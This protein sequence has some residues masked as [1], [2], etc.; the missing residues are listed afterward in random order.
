MGF[1]SKVKE[2][3][4]TKAARHCCVCHR[5]RGL[6]I[7]VHHI[8]PKAE[9][10]E[11]T[12][13]NAISLCFDCHA[14]AGHYNANHP[15][16]TKFSPSELR[17]ARNNWFK[18]VQEKSLCSP[19]DSSNLELHSRYYVTSELDVVEEILNSCWDNL[20]VKN[21]LLLKNKIYIFMKKFLKDNSRIIDDVNY[22]RLISQWGDSFKTFNEVQSKHSDVLKSSYGGSSKTV[23]ERSFNNSDLSKIEDPL[24]HSLY[25]EGID[26]SILGEAI[27]YEDFCGES[28]DGKNIVEQLKYRPIKFIFLEIF[29]CSGNQQSLTSYECFSRSTDK[30][31]PFPLKQA[32]EKP[33]TNYQLP[34]TKLRPDESILIPVGI[35]LSPIHE[36][37][38]NSFTIESS[39]S[40]SRAQ[41]VSR[42][43]PESRC[44][45]PLILGDFEFPTE[46]ISHDNSFSIHDF[47]ENSFY[48]IDRHWMCGS[49]PHL[50]FRYQENWIYFGEIL[51]GPEN[52][53]QNVEYMLPVGS[54]EIMIVEIDDELVDI[55]KLSIVDKN[56]TH[57]AQ[58]DNLSLTKSD[59][60]LISVPNEYSLNTPLRLKII[61]KYKTL[62]QTSEITKPSARIS[63]FERSLA[64][65]KSLNYYKM[66]PGSFQ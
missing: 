38:N 49:C 29:N 21:P 18:T 41:N 66:V 50:Y 10:G 52:T 34:G 23:F 63:K 64:Y 43:L 13:Q 16:G 55:S 31:S 9:G 19:S 11:D 65:E 14:D 17:K 54:S 58:R 27:Y 5:Y 8:K 45:E 44:D 6:K 48:S 39:H 2:N 33:T 3:C 35:L 1:S 12:E 24:T 40:G 53:M 32:F 30:L 60:L 25:K 46:M 59:E 51:S 4:L 57:I 28:E 37:K 22:P 26:I 15:K 62:F 36:D 42:F 56:G 61:G 20:P 47:K 7:E